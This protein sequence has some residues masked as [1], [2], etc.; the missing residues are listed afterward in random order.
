MKPQGK[1]FIPQLYVCNRSHVPRKGYQVAVEAVKPLNIL[2]IVGHVARTD[3]YNAYCA[4]L[5]DFTTKL[6]IA[7]VYL[8]FNVMRKGV[9]RLPFLIVVL[10][11]D[12]E[13]VK[14]ASALLSDRITPISCP[15]SIVLCL[16]FSEPVLRSAR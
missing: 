8:S 3:V 12:C 2:T 9:C 1:A 4:N 7:E 10:D 5:F 6:G 15:A 13:I 11:R 16:Y 14:D